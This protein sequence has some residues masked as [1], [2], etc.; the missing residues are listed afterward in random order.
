MWCCSEGAGW[1]VIPGVIFILLFWGAVVTMVV[2]GIRKLTGREDS[3]K[4]LADNRI[5]LDIAKERYAKGEISQ[6]E[7]EQIRKDL[8]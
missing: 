5:P 6:E 3:S 8:S 1:W 7:F 4:G 2:L